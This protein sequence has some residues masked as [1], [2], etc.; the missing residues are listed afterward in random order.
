MEE[1]IEN[2]IADMQ[3]KRDTVGYCDYVLD[4]EK[5]QQ[6][7]DCITKL[8][9]ENEKLK[10]NARGQVNDYFKDKYAEEVLKKC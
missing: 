8:K 3:R 2:V 1:E 9:Q 6:L 10:Y 4:S 7:L 5:A